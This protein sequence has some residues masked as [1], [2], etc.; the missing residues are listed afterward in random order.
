MFVSIQKANRAASLTSIP[1]ELG[2]VVLSV[3]IATLAGTLA[4]FVPARRAA[5]LNPIE[6]IRNG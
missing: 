5:R 1:V 6:V 4:A 3:A 2:A